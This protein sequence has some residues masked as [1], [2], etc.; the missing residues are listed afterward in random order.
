MEYSS[1]EFK[2]PAGAATCPAKAEEMYDPAPADGPSPH[3]R[4][5]TRVLVVDDNRDAADV[6]AL[7]LEKRGFDACV[8][9]DGE[10][11]LSVIERH[12]PRVALLDIDLPDMNGFEVARRVRRAHGDGI[13]LVAVTGWGN[14]SDRA[15]ARE[16]GFDHHFTK[17]VRLSQLVEYLESVDGV[18]ADVDARRDDRSGGA[19]S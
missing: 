18:F 1:D 19:S 2:G 13:G 3:D 6:L 5:P 8:A 4:R 17:P 9:Y 16:A 7:G 12:I 11:A 15:Y 14:D 10:S